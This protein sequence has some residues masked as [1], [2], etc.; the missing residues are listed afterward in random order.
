[1]IIIFLGFRF[2]CANHN[3]QHQVNIY[4]EK[5]NSKSH[6]IGSEYT[7]K[8]RIQRRE[9]ILDKL[10]HKC[11]WTGGCEWDITDSNMLHIHHK[12]Y[13]GADHRRGIK[14]GSNKIVSYILKNNSYSDYLL[15]CP[16]HHCKIHK[17]KI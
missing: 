2:L 13:N 7:K 11:M 14:G 9:I 5:W 3:W 15:L 1:M 12:D 10:E 17:E 16:N 8:S 4:K 6:S